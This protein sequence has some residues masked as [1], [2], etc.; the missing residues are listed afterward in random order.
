MK[1]KKLY[2]VIALVII[3]GGAIVCKTKGFILDFNYSNRQEIIIS[4]KNNLD[5]SK[6]KEIAMSILEGKKVKIQEVERFGNAVQII[7]T[8]ISDEEKKNIVDK[9]NEEYSDDISSDDIE[10]IKIPNTRIKD[11]FKPYIIPGVITIIVV[12]LYFVIMYNK[13]GI[14]SI[15]L[16]STIIPFVVELVYYALIAIIRLPIAIITNSIAVGLYVTCILALTINF[17]KQKE[18]IQK[19]EQK[20]ND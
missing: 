19:K 3:I 17:Q 12:L 6:V 2:I 14:I 8:E 20:E 18:T 1:E 15:L 11:I 5:V 13:L 10:V 9:I 7:S 4:T 16:K